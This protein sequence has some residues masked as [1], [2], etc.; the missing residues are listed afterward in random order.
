MDY[1]RTLRN[2]GV[3]H[4]FNSWTD[5][6]PIA[7]QMAEPDAFTTNF[8]VSRALMTPGRTYDQTVSRFTPYNC[9]REPNVQARDA[10]RTLL[11]RSKK[12]GEPTFIYVNN[13][14]EGFAPGTIAAVVDSFRRND[15]E[16]LDA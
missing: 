4:V 16:T 5:M 13:R 8:T 11:V 3:A 10:L 2:C 6:P 9:V 1:F 7:E 15:P 12:R 14:L